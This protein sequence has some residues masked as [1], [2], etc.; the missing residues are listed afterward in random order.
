MRSLISH[1]R[2]YPLVTKSDLLMTVLHVYKT[3]QWFYRLF[4]LFIQVKLTFTLPNATSSKLKQ[5]TFSELSGRVV[6]LSERGW[7]SLVTHT[8]GTFHVVTTNRDC[9]SDFSLG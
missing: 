1:K 5:G 6:H 7:I 4:K 8:P 3:R 9:K 2:R